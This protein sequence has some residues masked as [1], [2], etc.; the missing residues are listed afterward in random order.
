MYFTDKQIFYVNSKNRITGTDSSF[1]YAFNVDP[2]PGFDKV[3]MLSCSIPKSYYLVQTGSNTFTLQ[4]G[5]S[6]ATIT[7]PQ[8]NYSRASLA[9]TL[10]A[11]LNSSSPNSYNYNVTIPNTLTTVDLGYYTFTVSGNTY[12]PSFIFTSN[13]YEQLGFNINSTN[14]FTSNTLTSTNVCNLSNETTLFI[15]SDICQNKEGNDI[16]QEIYSSGDAS[17]AFINWHNPN[18]KE[19]AKPLTNSNSKMF[20]FTLTDENAIQI[21]LNGV[22]INFTIM[23]FKSNDIDSLIKGAIKYFTIKMD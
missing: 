18:P 21:N 3:V 15:H 9:I 5:T 20:N 8:G 22:N 1:T 4:E 17:F 12:Q 23:F 2:V 7:I 10:K 11:A 6:T 13:L 14:T 16:F 19:Y